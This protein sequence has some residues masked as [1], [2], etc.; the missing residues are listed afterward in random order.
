VQL[1]ATRNG[2]FTSD[3][4]S[5]ENL[6]L[7]FQGE[8]ATVVTVAATAA[9]ESFVVKQERFYQLGQTEALPTGVRNISAVVVKTGSAAGTTVTQPGNYEIDEARGRLRILKGSTITEGSTVYMSYNVGASTR[10]QVV[11]GSQSIYGSIRFVADNP[12]GENRDYFMPY[13]KLAPDGD[14]DLKGDDWLTI[15]F[16]MEILKKSSNT[17][18][19]YIDDQAVATP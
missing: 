4:I 16:T 17:A 11:S 8:E 19:L 7:F 3:N 6:A 10:K 18:P 1:S 5:R 9:T 13:V 12:K 2:A 14:Y 15:G